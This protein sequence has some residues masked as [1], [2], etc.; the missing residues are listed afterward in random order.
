MPESVSGGR[1]TFHAAHDLLS[2][3]G[4]FFVTLRTADSSA[5]PEA[6][7]GLVVSEDQLDRC[8]EEGG[9]EG[10]S[11]VWECP[12]NLPTDAELDHPGRWLARVA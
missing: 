1:E 6:P 3:G 12:A 9:L 11:A 10:A 5:E 2:P 7:A 8:R 4:W